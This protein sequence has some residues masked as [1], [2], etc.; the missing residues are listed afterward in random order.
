M[1]RQ[2]NAEIKATLKET[3]EKLDA[4]DTRL[5]V[6]ETRQ[7]SDTNWRLWLWGAAVVVVNALL[8]HYFG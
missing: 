4:I 7:T 6:V 2:D 8:Q 5:T 1:I 3:V